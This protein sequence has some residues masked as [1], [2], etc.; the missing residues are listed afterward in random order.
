VRT[1]ASVPPRGRQTATA[2]SAARTHPDVGPRTP[3][4][5][6][7]PRIAGYGPLSVRL[8][9]QP[10]V[11]GRATATRSPSRLRAGPEAQHHVATLVRR[12][13]SEHAGEFASRPGGGSRSPRCMDFDA[14][15]RLRV[16]GACR[17]APGLMDRL[18]RRP[19]RD[20]IHGRVPGRAR[21]AVGRCSSPSPRRRHARDRGERCGAT[22]RGR[23]VPTALLRSDRLT[24]TATLYDRHAARD[25]SVTR[26]RDGRRGLPLRAP[27]REGVW[28]GHRRAV[29]GLRWVDGQALSTEG[30]A[31]TAV[32]P[33]R[34]R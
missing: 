31:A 8:D 23:V 28:R 13:R 29:P 1:A 30:I 16:D 34:G 19:G 17:M 25:R 6:T 11:A 27:R 5:H 2:A 33:R 7:V 26:R 32:R 10:P 9:A 14:T 18:V 3:F 12:A 20:R 15:A 4:P 24:W 21:A 22:G